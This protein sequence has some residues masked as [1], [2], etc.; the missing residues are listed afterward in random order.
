M[1]KLSQKT[2][3]GSL[4]ALLLGSSCCWISSALLYVGLA[5]L[6]GTVGIFLNGI[7]PYLFALS[8]G[9]ALVTGYLFLRR[10]TQK[11][12]KA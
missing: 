9:M 1:K 8:G 6:S 2:F 10:K 11:Q 5:G 4:L 12:G 3:W 7:Q